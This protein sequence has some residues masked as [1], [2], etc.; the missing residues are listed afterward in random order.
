MPAE[1][2]GMDLFDLVI[3]MVLGKTTR[4]KQPCDLGQMDT[5]PRA[6]IRRL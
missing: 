4:A 3:T 6:D 5:E 1:P 2:D